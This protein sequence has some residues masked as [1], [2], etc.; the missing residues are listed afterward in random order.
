MFKA[1][2]DEKISG[3]AVDQGDHYFPNINVCS[4]YVSYSKT[5]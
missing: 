4:L 1:Q 3:Q 2:V 5:P